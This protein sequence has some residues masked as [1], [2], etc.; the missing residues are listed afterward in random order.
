MCYRDTMIDIGSDDF[1]HLGHLSMGT[2]QV[3]SRS[4]IL[5]NIGPTISLGDHFIRDY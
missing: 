2:G 3:L 5:P 4:V 1:C